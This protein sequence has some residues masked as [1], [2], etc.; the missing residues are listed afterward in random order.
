[1]LA[2]GWS[3]GRGVKELGLYITPHA[4]WVGLFHVLRQ[5]CTAFR[6][7]NVTKEIARDSRSEFDFV[8]LVVKV[9]VVDNAALLVDHHLE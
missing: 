9:Q 7:S 4:L 2:W 6:G 5:R 1:M 8:I 3:Q